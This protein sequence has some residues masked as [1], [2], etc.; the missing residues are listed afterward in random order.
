VQI[1]R[2]SQGFICNTALERGKG[3]VG[4]EEP[5]NHNG[6][7]DPDGKTNLSQHSPYSLLF[8]PSTIVSHYL[9]HAS[10]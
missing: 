1:P 7:R 3:E 10:L 9:A 2:N 6:V 5:R 4:N 8:Q